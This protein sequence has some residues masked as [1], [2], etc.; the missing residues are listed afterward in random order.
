MKKF[1]EILGTITMAGSVM[2]GIVA[3][4]PYQKQKTNLESINYKRQKRSNNE[5]NR[6][7]ITKIVI[8]TNKAIRSSGIIFNNKLYFGSIDHNVYEYDP[9]TINRATK[10][11]YYSRWMSW[12]FRY[13]FQ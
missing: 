8:T 12:I 6:I 13:Y 3:N 9:S 2:A 7:D 4:S 11:C 5:N 10:N 1:L